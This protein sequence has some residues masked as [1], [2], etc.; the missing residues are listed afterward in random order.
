[1]Y[2]NDP[3]N[4]TKLNQ[5]LL[6]YYEISPD[7]EM[8]NASSNAII[9]IFYTG[10]VYSEFV[11][12]YMRIYRWNETNSE[13]VELND[14]MSWVFG[15]GVDTTANYVWANVSHFSYYALGVP[16]LP[17]WVNLSQDW[18]MFG[19][20]VGIANYS[21]PTALTSIEGSYDW[22]FYFN[23]TTDAWQYFNPSMPQFSD[24]KTL[25]AGRGYFIQMTSNSTLN[26]TGTLL[27]GLTVPLLQDWNMFAPQMGLANYTLPAPL[28]SI[29]GS[30][31]WVFYFNATTDAW[32]YYNPSMPQFSDLQVLEPGR[33]YFIQM[34]EGANWTNG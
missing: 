3:F 33:G 15:A 21:L 17:A 10:K 2:E 24:L 18:N 27:T 14:S 31:D 29:A 12:D 8:S 26:F 23:A 32:Q 9:T 7:S 25:K 20:P 13:W 6:K 30:Y 16:Q 11:E 5:T 34:T 22:V 4:A 1:M 19:V 28:T